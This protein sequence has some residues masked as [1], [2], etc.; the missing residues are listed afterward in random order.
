MF[1]AGLNEEIKLRFF[2]TG[3]KGQLGTALRAALAGHDVI[4]ADQPDWDMTDARQALDAICAAA[5]DVVIHAAALTNVDFCAQNIRE[6]V[7]VNGVGTYNVALAC[8][9]S[10]ARM[11]AISTNEVFD[12]R[13]TR[14][15]MEYD[16]RN[17]IN[18]YGYSKTVAEQVV[19]RFAPHY[20]IVRTAWLYASGG[21][22]F[23]HKIIARARAN[24]PLRVVTDEVGSPTYCDDLA[25]GLIRLIDMGQ[26]GIFHLT[27]SG[28]CS[29]YEFART[30]LGLAGLA[31]VP[32]TPITSDEFTR[33]STPPL[34]CPLDNLFAAASG[35]VMRSWQDALA[36]YVQSHVQQANA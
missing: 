32:I 34:Y 25:E 29:R 30:I 24:E 10:G 31:D 35:I 8:R 1:A 12:G 15:Y 36:E 27:N 13:S 14:P 2:I 23:I 21:V 7:R 4:G 5:P 19:E 6:A 18:P 28:Q 3:H 26:P 20:Q 22:N 33:A 17:P 11:V 9:E 16:Q